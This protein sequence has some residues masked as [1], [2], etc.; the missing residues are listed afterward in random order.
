MVSFFAMFCHE[1]LE[2]L[3]KLDMIESSVKNIETK[4][5]CL[6]GRTAVVENFRQITEKDI[7]DLKENGNFTS[8]QL[9]EIST[10]L[11]K[12][13]NQVAITDLTQKAEASKELLKELTANNIY[14]EA[15]SRRE[16]IRL[17]R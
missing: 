10:E 17:L 7:N 8:S 13:Q 14:L 12:I 1:I 11:I 16:N 5:N 3:K 9:S 4:F 2:R 15:Y 6:E